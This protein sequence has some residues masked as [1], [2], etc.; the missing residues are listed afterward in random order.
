ML[1][2]IRQFEEAQLETVST[3]ERPRRRGLGVAVSKR[4]VS[5]T[6]DANILLTFEHFKIGIVFPFRTVTFAG[7]WTSVVTCA[8]TCSCK[9]WIP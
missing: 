4:T 6:I 3:E 8:V 9:P 1:S 2:L 7:F 5:H